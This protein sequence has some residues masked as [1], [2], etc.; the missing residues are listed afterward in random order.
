[1]T[2]SSVSLPPLAEVTVTRAGGIG[3][4]PVLSVLTLPSPARSPMAAPLLATALR[5]GGAV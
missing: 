5:T 1:M 2:T 4:R 3:D